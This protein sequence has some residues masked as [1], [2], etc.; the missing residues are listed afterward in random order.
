MLHSVQLKNM[1][2]YLKYLIQCSI[3]FYVI[4]TISNVLSIMFYVT[5]TTFNV[6]NNVFYVI[7]TILFNE[8]SIMFYVTVPYSMY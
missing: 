4:S 1:Y 7:S 6:L 2:S 3:T 5:S 8:L